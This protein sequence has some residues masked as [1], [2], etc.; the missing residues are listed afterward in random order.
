MK[1]LSPIIFSIVSVATVSSAS[2]LVTPKTKTLNV[3]KN[4]TTTSNIISTKKENETFK[5]E[6]CNKYQWCKLE[7][8]NGFIKE[9][10]IQKVDEKILQPSVPIKKEM[11]IAVETSQEYKIALEN[12]KNKNYQKSFLLFDKLLEQYPENKIVDFYYGRSAFELQ[13]YEYAFTSFDRI[14]INYPNDSRVRAEF[15]RTLMMMKSYKDAKKEFEAVLLMPIP[16]NVRKNIEKMIQVIESKEKNYVLNK[17]AIVGFGWDDNVENNTHLD[18][19]AYGSLLLDND[20]TKKEDTNFHAILVGNL[21]VP[22]KQ[23]NKLTWETTAIGYMQEQSKYKDSNIQ[24]I[25]LSTGLGV[26]STKTKN[27]ISMTY[28]HIWV[29]GTQM[30]NIYGITNNLKYKINTQNMLAFDFIFKNKKFFDIDNKDKNSKINEF[31][32]NYTKTLDNKK[33]KINLTSSYISEMKTQGSRT[34]VDKSTNKYKISFDKEIIPELSFNIGYQQEIN[35]Y[36]KQTTNLPLRND[37]KITVSSK[38]THPIDKKNILTLEYNNV[39]NKSNINSYSY[40]KQ[41]VNLNY[42]I[43]F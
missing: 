38:I 25:S 15:A 13:N 36:I 20:T 9:Y 14:L 2:I 30:L 11:K 39:E 40:K 32:L 34:D 37:N 29:A 41:S 12:F 16:Q 7:N 5:L 23:N 27:T 28:D 31:T 33:D 35:H 4:P 1:T 19:T 18:K 3:Y 26:S 10:L 43:I 8:S 22:N 17:I 21:I 24:L 42:T 6:Y